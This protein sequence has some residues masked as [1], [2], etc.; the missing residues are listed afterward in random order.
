M[1]IILIFTYLK[2][3]TEV[4]LLALKPTAISSIFINFYLIMLANN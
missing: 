1:G 4:A 2:E 3:G